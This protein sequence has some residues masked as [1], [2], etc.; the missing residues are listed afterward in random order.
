M[1][2]PR[3]K[4]S[5]RWKYVAGAHYRDCSAKPCEASPDDVRVGSV[6]PFELDLFD[7]AFPEPAPP[8]PPSEDETDFGPEGKPHTHTKLGFAGGAECRESVPEGASAGDARAHADGCERVPVL[9]RYA[10]DENGDA[11]WS[12]VYRGEGRG[13]VGA[14]AWLDG[15]RALAVGG[16]GCYPRREEPCASGPAADPNAGDPVAGRARAW[17]YQDWDGSGERAWRELELPAQMRGLTA[18]SAEP[19]DVCDEDGAVTQWGCA[20]AGGLRQIWH[21]RD[22]AFVT[23][24]S[25]DASAPREVG[26]PESFMFRVRDIRGDTAAT[27]GCCTTDPTRPVGFRLLKLSG[28]DWVVQTGPGDVGPTVND[29]IENEARKP[30]QRPVGTGWD[31]ARSGYDTAGSS[32]GGAKPLYDELVH[33]PNAWTRL[34]RD[35]YKNGV[36]GAPPLEPLAGPW[37]LPD[38]LVPSLPEDP[39]PE[40]PLPPN[41]AGAE[42]EA[43]GDAYQ[44]TFSQAHGVTQPYAGVGVNPG[45]A[46]DT[47]TQLQDPDSFYAL[48]QQPP[49]LGLATV[50]SAGGP[51]PGPGQDEPASVGAGCCPK[52]SSIRLV[53]ADET[54]V[55]AVNGVG[56]VEAVGVLRSSGQG[57]AW[58]PAERAPLGAAALCG[59]AFA[60]TAADP[61]PQCDLSVDGLVRDQASLRLFS[62]PSYAVNAVDVVDKDDGSGWAVGDHGAILSLG[63]RTAF[64][65]PPPKAPELPIGPREEGKLPDTAVYDRYRTPLTTDPGTVPPFGFGERETLPA[66]EFVATGTPEPDEGPP[67][68]NVGGIVMSRD[69]REG[70]AFASLV[71]SPAVSLVLYRFDGSTWRRCDMDGIPGVSGPDPACLELAPLRAAGVK[72]V[73]AVRVPLERDDDPS[74]DDELELVAVG[75]VYE[76][77]PVVVRYRHGRWSL[78][79]AAMDGIAVA[80]KTGAKPVADVVFTKPGDAWAV[81]GHSTGPVDLLHLDDQGWLLCNPSPSTPLARDRCGDPDGRLPFALG[82]EGNTVGAANF[83]GLRLEL[84]GE[85]VYV[86]GTRNIGSGGNIAPERYPMIVYRDPGGK[87]TDGAGEG[88][89]GGGFDPGYYAAGRGDRVVEPPPVD[90]FVDPFVAPGAAAADDAVKGGGRGEGRV[91]TVSVARTADGYEGFALGEFG[92]IGNAARTVM[93]RLEDGRWGPWGRR[94]AS[95]E[96]LRPAP[97]EVNQRPATAPDPRLHLTLPA[98]LGGHTSFLFAP[99]AP[100]AFNEGSG[101]SGADPRWQALR[102]PFI[103]QGSRGPWR[104]VVQ[105]VAPD[106]SGGLWLAVE[107]QGSCGGCNNGVTFYRYSDEQP[108]P[109]FRDVQNPVAGQQMTALAAGGDGSVWIGTGSDTL[110]RYDRLTG[111]DRARVPG[112]DP[113]RTTNPTAVNA[114]AVG[115]DG[116]GLAV[117][118]GGR[119]AEIGP[120]A[121]RLDAASGRA[122]D[123]LEPVAPCG[124]SR[125]LVTVAVA[126]DGSALAGGVGIESLLWRPAGEGF[127]RLRPPRLPRETV[128]KAVALPEPDRAYLLVIHDPTELTGRRDGGKRIYS[129]ELTGGS[130]RWRRELDVD[131]NPQ[132]GGLTVNAFSFETGGH[133]YAVGQGG[134]LLERSPDG[135]WQRLDSG[136]SQDLT[137]VALPAGGGPGALVGSDIGLVFTLQSGRL[138]VANPADGFNPVI[139][140]LQAASRVVGLALVPGGA[141]GQL[142]A[143]AAVQELRASYNVRGTQVANAL[144]HY[145]SDPADPLLDEASRV[146]PL[147]DSAAPRG[148]EL[149]FAALGKQDCQD[150]RFCVETGGNLAHAQ[151]AERVNEEL[152][153][154]SQRAGGPEFALFTGDA[155]DAPGAPNAVYTVET[156]APAFPNAKHRRWTELVAHRLA[157]GGL[158]LFGAIGGQDLSTGAQACVVNYG[159]AGTSETRG[160]VGIFSLPTRVGSGVNVRWRQAMA[161][162]PAPWQTQAPL[163]QDGIRYERV[164]D[165]LSQPSPEADVDVEDPRTGETFEASANYASARA[166]TRVRRGA[167]THYAVD[168]VDQESGELARIVVVDTS[169]GSLAASDPQQEPALPA[170]QLDW[171]ERMLCF[172]GDTPATAA[173]GGVCSRK[174]G[175]QAIVVSN[176]PTYSYGP[177][178]AS[179]TQTDAAAFEAVLMRYRTNMLVSGRLGWNGRYWAIA[180]GVHE[181]CPGGDYQEVPPASGARVCGQSAGAAGEL[182]AGAAELAPALGAL[183]EPPPAPVGDTLDGVAGGLLPAVVAAS[184]GGK[185]GLQGQAAGPARDGFWHGYTIVRL[186][187]SGDPRKTIVEQRP[188]LDWIGIR[189]Q[190]HTLRPGQKMTLRGYGREAAGSDQPLVYLDI[191]SPA[192]T[193][194]YDLVLADPDKPYLPLEDANGDYVS[195]PAQIATVDRQT[196]A[197]KAGRGSGERTYAIAILSVGDKAASYP[198]VFEP[199]RSFTPSRARTFLPP[200]PRAARAPAAQQPLRLSEAPP[201]PAPPP[202]TPPGAPL[203]TQSLQAPTPPELPS[204]PTINAAAPPP[205]PSLNAPPPPPPPPAPPPAPPQQQPLPLNVSAKVQAVAIVPSVNPPA[206]P[207]VNPA[208]PG[209]AAA[210]KEAKQ[211]QAAVAKSEESGN[212]SEGAG[213]GIDVGHGDHEMGTDGSAMTRL[214]HPFTRVEH[215]AQPSA[216]SRGALY[217]GGLGLAGIALALGFTVLRPRP[218]RHEPRLP[219]PAFARSLR[220]PGR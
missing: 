177:A 45:Q 174:P 180:P 64:Q 123:L 14:I 102:T 25:S 49:P 149:V 156:P 126:P 189:A 9:Y 15:S 139:G 198:L 195:V 110:H 188:V 135:S 52:L 182:P 120:R 162:V 184:A 217:G 67:S 152:L 117:G 111:W 37:P 87:W 40:D 104:G 56:R 48:Y 191:D 121:T 34:L 201:P 204:L 60:P 28:G 215:A 46:A 132:T 18:A 109:L 172:E 75:G 35:Y 219:A 79:Q 22:G 80:L 153:A 205:A 160:F 157:D 84:A 59:S 128:F 16:S 166:E 207:P 63:G 119:I 142:E 193:H 115:A 98:A 141:D 107:G 43:F 173:V 136:F 145:T 13:Y 88:G 133:G 97:H 216:W 8:A 42:D 72:L 169:Q 137:S 62:L 214:E 33:F 105:A 127:R 47:H 114:L 6:T 2:I 150:S 50:A 167:D 21:F 161:E 131:T 74:N 78:D 58:G 73:K 209:G 81:A 192:I 186:D 208:P 23:G 27:A 175:Q 116:E 55:A 125:D 155:V 179:D 93:M 61:V 100:V 220:R 103:S 218:R 90:G 3:A 124:T 92:G 76:G 71:G 134:L 197:L 36:P 187:G 130:W 200:L 108:R 211:K 202:A 96:Y 53:S 144:L 39:L 86:F 168:V 99:L 30:D 151:I 82:V 206:P 183:S 140:N 68:V 164:S 1:S 185:L 70:W 83:R 112:W 154:R 165:P 51:A 17:L 163:V 194:R 118:A 159:C 106:N 203:T 122:C 44:D 170:G 138:E 148:R 210:R 199:R 66:P 69:G 65:R 176:T 94:D 32:Y 158:P 20:A 95:D 4:P 171:A 7:V 146:E 26:H 101:A 91:Y 77:K 54:P 19:K 181:P 12:E 196:G 147:P 38:P 85:R 5:E 212:Q 89:E 31:A 24:W 213:A 57:I 10:V 178:G 143:W 113:A 41:P 29:P 11:G 129:G 190:E